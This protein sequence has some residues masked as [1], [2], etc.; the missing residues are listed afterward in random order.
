MVWAGVSLLRHIAA[1]DALAEVLG[2][3]GVDGVAVEEETG[4]GVTSHMSVERL[5]FV[6]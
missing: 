1:E 6:D 2:K 5:L 3:V 4:K